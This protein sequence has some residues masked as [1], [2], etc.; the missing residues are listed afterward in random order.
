I[1]T[2]SKNSIG[3]AMIVKNEVAV[4]ERCLSSVL[5]ILSHWT[6]VDTGS[7]D[8]TQDVI[9]RFMTGIPGTLHELPWENF[10]ANRTQSLRLARPHAEYSFVIDADDVLETVPG[11]SMS[12]LTHGV[13]FMHVHNGGTL[14]KRPHFVRNTIDWRYDGVVHEYLAADEPFERGFV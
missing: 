13:Y 4:I 8:G 1:M 7:T 10:A 12:A 6:I 14:Y 9:R 11:A 5:P 2:L 3:L